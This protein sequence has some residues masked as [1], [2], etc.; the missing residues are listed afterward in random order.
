MSVLLYERTGDIGVLTVN[1]PAAL[2]ALNS[3]VVAALA[4][5]LADIAASD[6]RCLIVTGAGEKSF[7][8]GADIA[9]MKDFAPEEAARF[10]RAGNEAMGL[11]EDLP[12][13]TI[14]CV[15][16][17]ALGGGCELAL[18]CDIR[19]ASE[20]S[21]FGLPE[22]GLG[23]LPGYGGVQRLARLVGPSA[24]KLL[25][26]TADRVKADRALR[27]GLVDEVC[28][29]EALCER[30]MELAGKIAANAPMGVRAVKK[31]ANAA[32]G[33]TLAEARGLEEE[34]F[35]RCFGTQDQK[36]AM[37]A[38]VNKEKPGPFTGK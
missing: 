24:A 35:A 21:L 13:P 2:N 23:I 22:V 32:A 36:V 31:V 14:A 11:L 29:P 12:M 3:E 27:L 15:N 26:Y 25:A 30:C 34:S 9:E 19:I 33:M 17:F 1:R 37:T 10:C 18:A 16:G 7:V 38:F 8:A 4:A 5:K 6:I 20:K 28:P